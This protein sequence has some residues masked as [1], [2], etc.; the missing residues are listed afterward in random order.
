MKRFWDRAEVAP[1]GED[2]AIRLDGRPVRLPGGGVLRA[3]TPGLAA[4]L[5]AEWQAAGG[6]KGG[7]MRWD[8]VPLTRLVGTAIER[9]APDPAATVEAIAA[10]GGSDLLCYRAEDPALAAKQARAWNPWLGW[11]RTELGA[12]LAVTEGIMPRP[13][14]PESLAA[15]HRAVAAHDAV[16]LSALGVLVPALG[17]LV[18][19]LAVTRGGL[20]PEGAHELSLVDEHHQESFWGLDAEAE[21]R[22]QRIAADIAT[23]ARL[24]AL[25]G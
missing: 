15:L 9:I 16:G 23:A 20:S 19:G 7:E 10:Y 2:H 12:A 14:P 6:A 24:A 25:A 5:A 22:R 18:L 11:A 21:T 3:R 13:Q 17:S 1:E 8:D 4:A